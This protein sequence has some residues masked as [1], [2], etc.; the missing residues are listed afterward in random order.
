MS[1]DI[2]QFILERVKKESIETPAFVYSLP[3]LEENLKA[4]ASFC[5]ELGVHFYY[6]IKSLDLVSV[7]NVIRE[8]V[9]GFAVSSYY[10]ALLIDEIKYAHQ[11]IHHTSPFFDPRLQEWQKRSDFFTTANS[12][13]QHQLMKQGDRA[14]PNTGLRINPKLTF[15]KDD[16]YNPSRKAS[17]LG[18]SL[19]KAMDQN[20]NLTGIHVHNNCESRDLSEMAQTIRAI[21]P[22]CEK[23][24]HTLKWINLGGGYM[25]KNST[26]GDQLM[27]ALK[28]LR[29]I[30]SGDIVLEPGCSIVEEMGFL[31]VK[32][33]DAF[34]DDGAELLLLDTSVNH[35]P[36][37][38]EYQYIAPVHSESDE[39]CHKYVLAGRSCLSG[40]LLRTEVNF[41]DKKK[42][43]DLLLF[44]KMGA[45]AFVKSHMFNGIPLPSQ[46]I[47]E[48]NGSLKPVFIADYS[49]YRKT[50]GMN[51][52]L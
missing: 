6:S 34:E 44:S 18:V 43:G 38:Y 8:Y 30:F 46:Y 5:K 1:L 12:L 23:N 11:K 50:R 31:A 21:L 26:N 16:R 27:M 47:L 15:V 10:E 17:K 49:D 33:V 42:I 40:D 29:Q 32:V 35:C 45:Y 51:V 36:E 19:S 22:L 4:T 3:T 7:L 28:E 37:I 13:G 41:N 20:L 25:F 52:S 24:Q 9:D 48:N 14:T 2:E 39:G